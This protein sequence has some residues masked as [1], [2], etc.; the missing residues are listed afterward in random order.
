MP[1]QSQI[2]TVSQLNRHVRSLL[3][4][5]MGAVCVEGE[6]S[7]LS[8]PASGHFYFT[9]KDAS[10]QLRCVYFRN[11]HHQG[12]N[13]L[14]NGQQVQARGTLSLY[15]ARGDYQLIVEQLDEAGQG[16]LYRQFEELKKKLANAGLFDDIRKK[17]LPRFPDVIGVISSATSAALKDILTTLK[18]RYP[19]AKVLV[20]ASEVQGIQAAPQLIRALEKA[21][22]DKQSDVLILARGGG[23][24]EDLWAFNDERLAYSIA[25]STIPIVT[26]I[27]HETDFS[28]ADFVADFRAAT[29]TAAA[30]S[31]TP[32]QFDLHAL[33]QTIQARLT[34]AITRI[35]KDRRLSL[36]HAQQTLNSPDQLIRR[37]WQT[38]DYL[39]NYLLQATQRILDKKTHR[40][41]VAQTRIQDLN[42]SIRI[43]QTQKHIHNLEN[44]L[45]HLA[46]VTLKERK[47]QLSRQ[48]ATLHAVSPLA[49][50]DRGYA[51]ASH[52]GSVLLSSQQVHV[53]D[54]VEIRLSHGRLLSQV[55]E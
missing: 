26:G 3:E 42:P 21:N 48:M 2:L 50:L 5:E 27:G 43:K 31:V 1:L 29:P 23:S 28:I 47:Q 45:I 10:A 33:L 18:R 35:I 8:K 17:N 25:A 13:S 49:T 51:I 55:I 9:L 12:F 14:E 11:R 39:R 40:V 36:K 41:H 16:D 34:N 6:I 20:Y 53:G 19:A 38:L 54:E 22:L 32:D 24:I 37:Y 30:E 52:N 46:S 4:Y 7:N 15:E 44:H